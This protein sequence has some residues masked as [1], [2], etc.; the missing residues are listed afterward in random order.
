MQRI[1]DNTLLNQ[2]KTEDSASFELLY[3][4]YFP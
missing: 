1:S 3:Q 4:F 2:L